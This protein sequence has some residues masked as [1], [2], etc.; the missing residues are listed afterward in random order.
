MAIPTSAFSTYGV[1]WPYSASAAGVSGIGT[2]E[3]AMNTLTMIDPD[4]AMSLAV[5]GKTTTN[6]LRHEWFIDTLA[7]TNNTPAIQGEDWGQVATVTNIKAINKRTRMWNVVEFRRQDWSIT[8]DEL[9]LSQRG[10]LFGVSSEL[11]YQIGKGAQEVNRNFD[12]RLWQ[13]Y[14]GTVA[15]STASGADA[16]IGTMGTFKFW[17]SAS[18]SN[19]S[20]GVSGGA[21]AT[22]SFYALQESMWTNGAKP[23]TLFVSPGVKS[24]ISRTLLGDVAYPTAI[25]NA[26]VPG[27]AAANVFNGGEYGPVVDFIRTDFGRVAMVVD[28]WIPQSSA[29]AH[30]TDLSQNAG[31]FL[32]ERAK[33]RVAW[34]RPIQ[35]YQVAS[36]GDNVKVYLLGAA[37]VEVLHPSCIGQGYNITT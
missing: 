30:A 22:A 23:D 7:V 20:L 26:G 32:V 4:E 9:M 31:F 25:G 17:A 24:D 8:M 27:L 6:G 18:G 13:R 33:L 28:R 14:D 34:W 10:Q 1:G 5:L 15:Y 35:P 19:T 29:T 12:A 3:N 36:T 11:D 2:R 21:F 37:T 16:T